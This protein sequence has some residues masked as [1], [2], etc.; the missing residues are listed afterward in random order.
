M[1]A[2]LGVGGLEI[3]GALTSAWLDAGDLQD[4]LV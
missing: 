3:A 2:G 1:K 4:G